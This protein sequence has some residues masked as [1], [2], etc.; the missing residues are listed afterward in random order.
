MELIH[1]KNC[2]GP[3]ACAN[4][5]Y[6]E[7]TLAALNTIFVLA[8]HSYAACLDGATYYTACHACLPSGDGNICNADGNL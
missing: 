1:Y 6:S 4:L 5:A 2:H 7:K 3:C 8:C